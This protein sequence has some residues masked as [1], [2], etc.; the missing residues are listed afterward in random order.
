MCKYIICIL[1]SI[2]SIK[3]LKIHGYGG[4]KS[5]NNFSINYIYL[6]Q[7]KNITAIIYFYLLLV[8]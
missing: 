7:Y 5:F 6:I 4:F 1:I 8:V 2:P 3:G